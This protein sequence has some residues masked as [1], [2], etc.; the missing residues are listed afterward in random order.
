MELLGPLPHLAV[1]INLVYLV[2][3]MMGFRKF[4]HFTFALIAVS[5]CDNHTVTH[6]GCDNS[7]T[8]GCD[9]WLPHSHLHSTSL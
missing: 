1:G 3:P 9:P 6:G 8:H 4:G 2:V 7:H 5:C